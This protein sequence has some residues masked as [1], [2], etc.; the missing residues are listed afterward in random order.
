[1]PHGRRAEEESKMDKS[2]EAF[3]AMFGDGKEDL[4]A[5]LEGYIYLKWPTLYIYHLRNLVRDPSIKIRYPEDV[6]DA[7]VDEMTR[8]AAERTLQTMMS[9]DTNVYHGKILR[10]DEAKAII[11]VNRNV[12]LTNLERVIPYKHARDIILNNPESIAVMRC[13][14]R[15]SKENPCE[16]LDVCMG[17][18][19]PFV[20]FILEHKT[21]NARKLSRDE[22]VSIIKAED[23]RGHIHS[24][25]FKDAMGSRFYAICNCCKC[26]CSAMRGHSV[27][28]VP[29]LA[30][31]GYVAQIG[32]DCNACGECEDYCQFGAITM[33][34]EAQIVYEKCMGCG[35]CESKCKRNAITLVRDETKGEP[36]DLRVL[37]PQD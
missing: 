10:L 29:T 16:P 11:N 23:D 22:A 32:E 14:C 5:M 18:G 37:A 34:G 36:M 12:T 7:G 1:M 25:W 17:I 26:C 33:N 6:G 35:V 28:G 20:S 13:P 3:F 24:A 9:R 2:T 31:S 8:L 19:E 27:F 21:N 15:E 30:S 4:G